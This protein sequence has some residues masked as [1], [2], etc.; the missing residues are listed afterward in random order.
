MATHTPVW[1]Y[2]H[3]QYQVENGGG[4]NS[5][6][7]S[8]T[9]TR[10]SSGVTLMMATCFQ[11]GVECTQANANTCTT[12][13]CSGAPCRTGHTTEN[14]RSNMCLYEQ[15]HAVRMCV[16]VLKHKGVLS[17]QRSQSTPGNIEWMCVYWCVHHSL[18]N[19]HTNTTHTHG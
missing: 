18:S 8:L 19:T 16:W 13:A 6:Y 3:S 2:Q 10:G 1:M 9:C 17:A 15:H 14:R 5:V 7:L 11:K 12:H 4:V